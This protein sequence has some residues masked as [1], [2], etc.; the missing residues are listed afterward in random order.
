VIRPEWKESAALMKANGLKF[1]SS[2][3]VPML[4]PSITDTYA[5]LFANAL[6]AYGTPF[7]I[8][9]SNLPILS[10]K[11]TM[12]FGGDMTTQKELG[13]ALSVTMLVLILI[14][15]TLCNLVKKIFYKGGIN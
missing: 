6:T 12:M 9:S 5:I 15:I 7:I 2:V 3:G 1:W 13:S 10:I 11:I 8:I 14:V 4:I